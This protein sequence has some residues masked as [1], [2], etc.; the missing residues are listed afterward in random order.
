[1]GYDYRSR[2]IDYKKR[3]S[4]LLR[5]QNQNIITF[6]ELRDQSNKMLF[7]REKAI[8]DKQRSDFHK[9]SSKL[10]HL[11][12][13][14]MI[15]GVYNSPYVPEESKPIVFSANV[16]THLKL[17]VKDALKNHKKH[18]IIQKTFNTVSQGRLDI[19]NKY[20]KDNFSI[21][22]ANNKYGSIKK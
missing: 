20:R 21:E 12:S 6:N 8:F 19:I 11:V 14:K 18:K 10:H 4:D 1:M 16:E 3:K 15:P 17:N 7:L 2:N 5:I 22:R 9:V 13:T